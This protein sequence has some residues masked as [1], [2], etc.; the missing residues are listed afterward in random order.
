[1]S[2]GWKYIHRLKTFNVEMMLKYVSRKEGFI[3]FKLM[4]IQRWR[5]VFLILN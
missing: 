5:L 2:A 1:M 3:Y 4:R